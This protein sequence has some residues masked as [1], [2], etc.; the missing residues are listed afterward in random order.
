MM[1]NHD[2]TPS[3]KEC[4]YFIQKCQLCYSGVIANF[5]RNKFF[6]SAFV[7]W[8]VWLAILHF[9]PKLLLCTREQESQKKPLVGHLERNHLKRKKRKTEKR[10]AM[11]ER[12][13]KKNKRESKD[14]RNAM[15]NQK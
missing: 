10:K 13:I 8:A 5:V 7:F 6:H 3:L 11:A 9:L 2:T 15:K 1:F 4:F 14:R 12:I